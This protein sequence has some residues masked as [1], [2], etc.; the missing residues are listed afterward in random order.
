MV[1]QKRSRS[2]EDEM[3]KRAVEEFKLGLVVAD[4]ILDRFLFLV[5]ESFD[6][7][8][9]SPAGRKENALLLLAIAIRNRRLSAEFCTS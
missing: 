1:G 6:N 5:D 4:K 8:E 7:D 2:E 3:R 9:D